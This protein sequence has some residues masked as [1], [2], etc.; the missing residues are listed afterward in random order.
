MVDRYIAKIQTT[1]MA[2]TNNAALFGDS[3]SSD[4]SIKDEVLKEDTAAPTN[5]GAADEKPTAEEPATTK[6]SNANLF[7][8]DSSDDDEFD[9]DDGIV[10]KSADASKK[11]VVGSVVNKPQT[12]S[13]R[14]G[15][16]CVCDYTSCV[17]FEDNC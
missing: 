10:G 15:E 2:S 5:D 1:T 6:P 7:G 3:D 13:E 14:L 17:H 4:E 12:M 11:A 9:G 16:F 8:D